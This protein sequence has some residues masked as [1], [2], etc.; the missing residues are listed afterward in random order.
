MLTAT[1]FLDEALALGARELEALHNDELDKV[2]ALAERRTWLI[3]QAWTA[4]QGCDSTA[5]KA[6][7]IQV[8]NLQVRLTEETEKKKQEVRQGLLRSRKETRRLAGY[9][10]AMT[11]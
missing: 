4:R 2:S 7:L 10:Q 6:K 9:K 11:Y 3:S 5:Y 8:Q 1:E